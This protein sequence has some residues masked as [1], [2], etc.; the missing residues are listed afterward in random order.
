MREQHPEQ[1]GWL[2]PDAARTLRRRL[3]FLARPVR[4]VSARTEGGAPEGAR[5][6]WV[7]AEGRGG[8]GNHGRASPG[9]P[10]RCSGASV[11]RVSHRSTSI[12]GVA[13]TSALGG[14]GTAWRPR[15]RTGD[16]RCCNPALRTANHGGRP[17]WLRR[18]DGRDDPPGPG[19]RA[20][21]PRACRRQAGSHSPTASAL[22]RRRPSACMPPRARAPRAPRPAAGATA[23]APLTRRGRPP[24]PRPG[25]VQ[26][27]CDALQRCD[28]V[29]LRHAAHALA[30]TAATLCLRDLSRVRPPQP[31]SIA[32]RPPPRISRPVTSLPPSA[33]R[34]PP[35]P[36]PSLPPA[37]IP[38]RP[39]P[40]PPPPPASAA[41]SWSG[42]RRSRGRLTSRWRRPA[43]ASRCATLGGAWTR[44]TWCTST[45]AAWASSSGWRWLRRRVERAVAAAEM[46]GGGRGRGQPPAPP[47]RA[48]VRTDAAGGV[49]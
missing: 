38:S 7:W 21:F 12:G 31:P 6:R 47:P 35:P 42:W 33:T 23:G 2:R 4:H 10:A 36:I 8:G 46:R 40:P 26:A 25:Q 43:P 16:R 11:G 20:C 44:W 13:A 9:F 41:R 1:D 5:R 30:G 19:A 29:A 15:E 3:E 27:M 39:A 48:R 24:T 32:R 18:F 17:A 14:V 37:A 22:R 45:C 34:P 49:G 28:A